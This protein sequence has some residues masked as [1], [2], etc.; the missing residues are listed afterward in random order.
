MYL[1]PILSEIVPEITLQNA[2][3]VQQ[4]LG[5]IDKSWGNFIDLDWDSSSTRAQIDEIIE[6]HQRKP[7]ALI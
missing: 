2:C 1:G 4:I 5:L 3:E 6:I 7:L